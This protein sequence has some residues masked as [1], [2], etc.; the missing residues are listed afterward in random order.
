[1]DKLADLTEIIEVRNPRQL[2]NYSTMIEDLQSIV[3]MAETNARLSL[4]EGYH[5]LG[6]QIID[7]GLDK[8]EYLSQVS[9]DLQKSKRTVYRVLQFVRMFP[10]LSILPEGNNVSW[11]QI[12]NKYLV[13][14]ASE[15]PEPVIVRHDDLVAFIYENSNFLAEKAIRTLTGVT[16]RI[17]KE[18]LEKYVESR[19]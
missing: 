2:E 6:M 4:V 17:T 19:Q 10:D 5:Q 11:H 14:K 16:I 8:A 18:Q 3:V 13:G 15:E 1:M 9:Q 7:Y 12:C